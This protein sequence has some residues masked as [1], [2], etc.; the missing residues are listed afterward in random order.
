MYQIDLLKIILLSLMCSLFVIGLVLGCASNLVVTVEV[1][2]ATEQPSLDG[3]KIF[4][5]NKIVAETDYGGMTRI[6]M[7]DILLAPG[8]YEIKAFKQ[9]NTGCYAGAKR[10]KIIPCNESS[11]GEIQ[12]VSL[13]AKPTPCRMSY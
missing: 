8:V 10:Q 12:T 2:S 6:A 3:F 11:S 5:N 13:I 4:I 1:G 9:D 7:D